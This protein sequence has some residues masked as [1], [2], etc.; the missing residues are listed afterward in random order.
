MPPLMLE[1]GI[2][3]ALMMELGMTLLAM[4]MLLL[5]IIMKEAMSVVLKVAMLTIM[6]KPILIVMKEAMLMVMEFVRRLS[7]EKVMAAR[8][9]VRNAQASQ[10]GFQEHADIQYINLFDHLTL[11]LQELL[12]KT[13]KVYDV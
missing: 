13:K 1:E 3:I 4:L 11:R 8:G 10:I 9:E 12:L 2:V 7:K 5:L 6:K